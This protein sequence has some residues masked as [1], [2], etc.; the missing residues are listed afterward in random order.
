MFSHLISLG[1]APPI[2]ADYLVLDLNVFNQALGDQGYNFPGRILPYAIKH[3]TM[4]GFVVDL[5][6]MGNIAGELFSF[7]LCMGLFLKPFAFFSF[8][9]SFGL[10][11]CCDAVAF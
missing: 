4:K 3:H 1:I 2:L 11:D 8:G 5:F 6:L 9:L 7:G 10:L